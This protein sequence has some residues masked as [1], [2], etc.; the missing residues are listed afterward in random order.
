LVCVPVLAHAIWRT[1]SKTSRNMRM[2]RKMSLRSN[3]IGLKLVE[4]G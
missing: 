4:I 2:R 1:S 3:E